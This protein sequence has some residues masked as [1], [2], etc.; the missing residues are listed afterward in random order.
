MCLQKA[1]MGVNIKVYTYL[2]LEC[3]FEF[4]FKIIYKFSHPAIVFVIF[5]AIADKNIIFKPRDQ[6]SWI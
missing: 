3:R 2:L 5:L 1:V 4:P 6:A